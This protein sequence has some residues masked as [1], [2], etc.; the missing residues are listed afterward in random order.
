MSERIE[1]FTL[2]DAQAVTVAGSVGVTLLC[3]FERLMPPHKRV[4]KKIKSVQ[5]AVLN[6]YRDT[7]QKVDPRVSEWVL[8]CWDTAVSMA[9]DVP[10]GVAT[11]PRSGPRRGIWD[12]TDHND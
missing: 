10:G 11:V 9:A 12:A 5:E 3:L 8:K 7:G 6:L 2:T 4:A 1:N